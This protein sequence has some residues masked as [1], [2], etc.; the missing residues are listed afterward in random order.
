MREESSSSPGDKRRRRKHMAGGAAAALALIVLG[1]LVISNPLRDR[2]RAERV[3]PRLMDDI[4][5]V[6]VASPS[7]AKLP[8]RTAGPP[9]AE[10]DQ[11]S[12]GDKAPAPQTDDAAAPPTPAHLAGRRAHK[13]SADRTVGVGG[14]ASQKH[15][16]S[17]AHVPGKA[18]S[19]RAGKLSPDDF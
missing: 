15:P 2:A 19:P 7:P 6:N 1:W 17:I 5:L 18:A 14:A 9:T 13:A 8:T 12:V 4:G 10:V 11:A 16:P 3:V